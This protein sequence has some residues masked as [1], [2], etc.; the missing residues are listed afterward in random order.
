[1][2]AQ[3]SVEREGSKLFFEEPQSIPQTEA[4]FPAPNEVISPESGLELSFGTSKEGA[5][6]PLD[7]GGNTLQKKGR[8][9]VAPSA[10]G[11]A[12]SSR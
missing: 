11:V 10:D 3:V 8:V 6:N 2:K 5:T 7:V 1:M 12:Q 4:L 9:P